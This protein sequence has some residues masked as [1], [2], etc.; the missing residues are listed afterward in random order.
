[1]VTAAAVGL[2]QSPRLTHA[3]AAVQAPSLPTT[4]PGPLPTRV[5]A[6][7]TPNGSGTPRPGHR[8]PRLR[9]PPAAP[10]WFWGW[11]K[12]WGWGRGGITEVWDTRRRFPS[13]CA[14]CW[15]HRGPR[16]LGVGGG[17]MGRAG[18]PSPPRGFTEEDGAGWQLAGDEQYWLRLPK[19][20]CFGHPK[21]G[22]S[23][24]L[25]A[26]SPSGDGTG[27]AAGLGAPDAPC[28]YNTGHRACPPSSSSSPG[29]IWGAG[30]RGAGK[31]GGGE[32]AGPV[33]KAEVSLPSP[34]R[35]PSTTCSGAG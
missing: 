28:P 29:R 21:T 25:P 9:S 20:S 15:G 34:P 22:C 1:M 18:G 30:T 26:S 3:R 7:L 13:G 17:S 10:G 32:P 31:A 12:S 8:N 6:T 24:Q 14:W 4:H 5:L 2:R 35:S 19:T 27:G 16:A 23:H 11:I 33:P